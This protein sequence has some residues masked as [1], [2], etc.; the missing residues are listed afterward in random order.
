M[1]VTLRTLK[2]A[3][4]TK[5]LRSQQPPSKRCGKGVSVGI[6]V[7]VG[8]LAGIGV[9]VVFSSSWQQSARLGT[10]ASGVGGSVAWAVDSQ[11]PLHAPAHA[12]KPA[13]FRVGLVLDKGGKD[14]ESYNASAYKGAMRAQN[15]L[16]VLIKHV[17]ATDE[18]AFEPF[19]RNFVK[20]KFDLIIS[21]GASQASAVEKMAKLYP[22]QH[23]V[24][25]DAQLNL[26][27]INS[28]VF[29]EHEGSF[30]AGALA[31]QMSKTGK[32][33]FIGGMEMPLLRRFER[34]YSAGAHYI[35]PQ[36]KVMVNYVGVTADAWSNPAKGKELALAQFAAG[37]DVI[38]GAAGASGI[39]LFDAAEEQHKWVIGVDSN[40]N[41]VRPGT[42]L[43]SMVKKMD[44]AVF[45]VC[46][47][48]QAGQFE[49]GV[50]RF[51]LANHGVELA[52]DHFNE[53]LI[54]AA[55]RKKLQEIE[56]KIIS[57][58]LKV[59]DFYQ[60]GLQQHSKSSRLNLNQAPAPWLAES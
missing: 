58:E 3:L 10:L 29:Q 55:V 8:V 1:S 43:T 33:G 49:A 37:V 18:N 42:V 16:H 51:N 36:M 48:S 13:P 32:L 15:E 5:G 24:I 60:E 21:I 28:I 38:Y 44:E 25:L 54:P 50:S 46:K 6:F 17:E 7:V 26:P 30:L 9:R 14:D 47:R 4:L 39:G 2:N 22:E 45:A 20:K 59:P 27:N 19:L 11:A 35:H 56:A 12:E 53:K 41:G 23:F 31:A 57:G 34:G 52:F 40:Q